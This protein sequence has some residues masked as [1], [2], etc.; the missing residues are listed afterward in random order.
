MISRRSILKAGLA[1]MP[2]ITIAQVA[3]TR[4]AHAR[5]IYDGQVATSCMVPDSLYSGLTSSVHRSAHFNRSGTLLTNLRIVLPNFY[6][7]QAPAGD[8]RT[9][10]AGSNI[11]STCLQL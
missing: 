1:A 6:S 5:P 8:S 7:K 9:W 10:Q 2:T 3:G 11:R 4:T